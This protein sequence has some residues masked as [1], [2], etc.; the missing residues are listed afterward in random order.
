M[1]PIPG[2][3][4]ATLPG[5]PE[6]KTEQQYA[7]ASIPLSAAIVESLE[8]LADEFGLAPPW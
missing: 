2:Y 5:G 3:A 4:E 7:E 8:K 6:W 1:Q